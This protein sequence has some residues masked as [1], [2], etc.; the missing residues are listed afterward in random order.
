MPIFVGR[1]GIVGDIAGT[2]ARLECL[3]SALEAIGR[4]ER[5]TQPELDDAPLLDPYAVSTFPLPCLVGG[6]GGHPL[7]RSPVIRTSDLW[8]FAPELAWARTSGR[9]YRLGR[10]VREPGR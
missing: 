10:P 6:N 1:D 2:I 8:L 9:L 4:G 5:P 3:L 7:C